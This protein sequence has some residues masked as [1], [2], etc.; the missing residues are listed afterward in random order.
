MPR[1]LDVPT[2]ANPGKEA[3]RFLS[4]SLTLKGLLPPPIPES[5]C[6][7][8]HQRHLRMHGVPWTATRHFLKKMFFSSPVELP[9]QR[10]YMC[11]PAFPRVQ[12]DMY[13]QKRPC[14]F[15]F[16]GPSQDETGDLIVH[17]YASEHA[18]PSLSEG[19]MG[20]WG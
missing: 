11:R 9:L 17:I 15:H 3:N 20:E 18:A 2:F 6:R 7:P 10:S 14:F 13:S 16:F 5:A 4:P 19:W 1:P 8:S 12:G